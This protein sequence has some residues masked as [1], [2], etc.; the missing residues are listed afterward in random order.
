MV[1]IGGLGTILPA[2]SAIDHFVTPWT[3]THGTI[4]SNTTGRSGLQDTYQTATITYEIASGETVVSECTSSW[5]G[6]VGDT[7][8]VSY[9]ESDPTKVE[10]DPFDWGAMTLVTVLALA[11]LLGG[12]YIMHRERQ[13]L[14]WER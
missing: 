12:L 8:P 14:R 11:W 4:T 1:M 9:S 13:W 10:C 7:I 6:S 3:E 5:V 2:W